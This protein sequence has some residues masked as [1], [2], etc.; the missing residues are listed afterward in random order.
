[1]LNGSWC[2]RISRSHQSRGRAGLVLGCKS[3]IMSFM[4][5][6]IRAL[7]IVTAFACGTRATELHPPIQPTTIAFAL[8]APL[9]SSMLQVQLSIDKALV[10]TDTFTTYGVKDT[11]S[12]KFNVVAGQHIV[13]ANVIGGYVW[14]EKLVTVP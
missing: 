4:R 13:S 9:C 1:P 12:R 3:S 14:P 11:I 2:C 10:A 8:D 6:L 5:R 7:V